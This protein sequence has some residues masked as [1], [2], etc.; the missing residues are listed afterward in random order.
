[1]KDM[2]DKPRV[3]KIEKEMLSRE[4]VK[5]H[6]FTKGATLGEGDRSDEESHG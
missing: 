5:V 6:H 3:K 4:S 2:L 1:M